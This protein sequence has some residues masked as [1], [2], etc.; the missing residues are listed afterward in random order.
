MP[1][2]LLSSSSTSFD[3]CAGQTDCNTKARQILTSTSP[4]LTLIALTYF[5]TAGSCW[6]R[7]S[8]SCW[9]P[10]WASLAGKPASHPAL[11]L[12]L[13]RPRFD[14]FD[15]YL[16]IRCTSRTNRTFTPLFAPAGNPLCTCLLYRPLSNA[17]LISHSGKEVRTL[18]KTGKGLIK[19][20]LSVTHVSYYP[21][22]FKLLID[23]SCFWL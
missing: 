1:V 16:L 11:G 15:I 23:Q 3:K 22:F 19:S 6:P 17:S 21:F 12:S 4:S 8:P 9:W 10:L 18:R 13:H 2:Q 14:V 5:S 20:R 7:G